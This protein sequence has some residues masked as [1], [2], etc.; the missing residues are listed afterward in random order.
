MDTVSLEDQQNDFENISNDNDIDL[1]VNQDSIGSEYA[2]QLMVK[3]ESRANVLKENGLQKIESE[4][5]TQT[6]DE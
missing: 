4:N 5:I 1:F 2:K 6:F 3:L